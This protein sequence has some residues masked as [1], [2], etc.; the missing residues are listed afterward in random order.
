[1]NLEPSNRGREWRLEFKRLSGPAPSAVSLPA[2]LGAGLPFASASGASFRRDGDAIRIE[3][4]ATDWTC[5]WR[6]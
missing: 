3:P 1:M 4:D 6:T 5:V 2:Q